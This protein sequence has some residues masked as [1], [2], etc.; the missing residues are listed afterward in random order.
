MKVFLS[1]DLGEWKGM[2]KG[3]LIIEAEPDSRLTSL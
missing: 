2:V 3:N 1:V